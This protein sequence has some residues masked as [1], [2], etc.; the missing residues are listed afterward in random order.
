MYI[1]T[2]IYIQVHSMLAGREVF[3][4]VASIIYSVKTTLSYSQYIIVYM[5]IHNAARQP[6]RQIDTIVIHCRYRRTTSTT[7]LANGGGNQFHYYKLSS[8]SVPEISF[9]SDLCEIL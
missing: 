3:K 6:D 7:G 2:G 5:Y 1:C 8:D 4:R 9:L